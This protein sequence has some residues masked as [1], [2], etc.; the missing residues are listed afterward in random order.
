MTDELVR[1]RARDAIDGE[2]VARMLESRE[3][4]ALEN[5]AQDLLDALFGQSLHEL[6]RAHG[7]I[8]QAGGRGDGALRI[9]RMVEQLDVH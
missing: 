8:A 9:W 3:M 6:G 5:G 4:T 1:H 2:G 7:R